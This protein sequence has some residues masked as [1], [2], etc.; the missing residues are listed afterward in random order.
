MK[1]GTGMNH[2]QKIKATLASYPFVAVFFTWGLILAVAYVLLSLHLAY[3]TD[4]AKKGGIEMIQELSKKVG[5]PLL[6][7][8]TDLLQAAVAEV[9]Q[10]PGVLL[11]WVV[12]HQNKVVAFAGNN[13]ILPHARGSDG[14]AGDVD[15]WLA[16]SAI[17]P[18][19]FNL[20]SAVTYSGIR[21]GRIFLAVAPDARTDPQAHFMRL[22]V[23]SG[24]FMLVLVAAFYHRQLTAFTSQVSGILRPRGP[25]KLD[26][27]GS[28]VTCPLCGKLQPLSQDVFQHGDTAALVLL[29]S[30]L[31]DFG[32][33][34]PGSKKTFLHE[35]GDRKDLAWIKQRIILRCTDI[36]RLL[37]K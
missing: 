13:Q 6:E 7:K 36:I 26:L 22:V 23:L 3:Q 25:E 14:R 33:V 1:A 11:I 34:R 9:G 31:V 2:L 30:P 35:M 4:Q 37:S 17:P 24:V 15:I 10:R 8:N 20:V 29:N 18:A 12:D 28:E 5:L 21:I 32:S 27:S 16:E 19:Y